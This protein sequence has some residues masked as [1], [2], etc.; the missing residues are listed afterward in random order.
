[1]A[2]CNSPTKGSVAN[3]FLLGSNIAYLHGN[4]S[5]VLAHA[6]KHIME[7][8]RTPPKVIDLLALVFDTYSRRKISFGR[9]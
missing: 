4:N 2:T 1:M 7:F 8:S 9:L 5:L 6:C 3:L